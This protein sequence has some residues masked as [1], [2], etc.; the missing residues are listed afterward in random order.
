MGLGE[1][2]PNRK[3]FFWKRDQKKNRAFGPK[4]MRVQKLEKKVVFWLEKCEKFESGIQFFFP[5]KNFQPT[6]AAEKALFTKKLFFSQKTG[7]T[8]KNTEKV[9]NILFRFFNFFIFFFLIFLDFF[10]Y[11]LFF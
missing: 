7:L 8:K 3:V 2:R 11:Y 9:K 1:G 5:S 10:I 4:T 6:N